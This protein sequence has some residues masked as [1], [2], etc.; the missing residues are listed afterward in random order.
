MAFVS[1]SWKLEDVRVRPPPVSRSK[2]FFFGSRPWWAAQRLAYFFLKRIDGILLPNNVQ[3]NTKTITGRRSRTWRP[4]L[5]KTALHA[6][7]C[8][9][10][11]E[12]RFS[13]LNEIWKNLT[14]SLL[15]PGGSCYKSNKRLLHIVDHSTT[16]RCY[17][18]LLELQVSS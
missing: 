13:C 8:A 17:D 18:H 14:L 15:F 12:A 7:K 10:E 3:R 6:I 11:F 4:T 16:T 2:S 1:S 5:V 9:S